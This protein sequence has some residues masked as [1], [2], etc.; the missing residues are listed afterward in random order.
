MRC[1]ARNASQAKARLICNRNRSI[2]RADVDLCLVRAQASERASAASRPT[3]GLQ[4]CR[5]AIDALS[6]AST[7][8]ARYWPAALRR[9]RARRRRPQLRACVISAPQRSERRR[10]D[11]VRARQ[12]CAQTRLVSADRVAPIVATLASSSLH[13]A[14][15]RNATNRRNETNFRSIHAPNCPSVRPSVRSPADRPTDLLLPARPRPFVLGALM[16]IS[17]TS[18][19]TCCN[20]RAPLAIAFADHAQRA[21]INGLENKTQP[22]NDNEPNHSNHSTRLDAQRNATQ[23]ATQSSMSARTSSLSPRSK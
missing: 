8:A 14:T 17:I 19:A 4:R 22:A 7:R 9:P 15:Q 5:A 18:R 3:F 10:R 16:N 11:Q 13:C 23:R 2:A 20:A 1:A 12:V 6:F 21:T